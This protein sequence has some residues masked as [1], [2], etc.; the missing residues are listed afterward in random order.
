MKCE[1][2]KYWRSEGYMGSCKRFPKALTKGNND[3]CGEFVAR[4]T[5]TLPVVEMN[6]E[7]PRKKPGRPAKVEP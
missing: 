3:W 5:L 1:D 6:D 2:C 4:Q 7:Q